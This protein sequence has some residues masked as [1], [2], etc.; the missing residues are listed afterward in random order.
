MKFVKNSSIVLGI[1]LMTTLNIS[2]C[3]ASD[4]HQSVGSIPLKGIDKVSYPEL[5][6]ISLQDAINI[7]SKIHP[8]KII[9]VALEKEAGFLVYEVELISSDNK[10]KEIILDAGNGEVLKVEVKNT[11]KR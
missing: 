6:K 3:F 11:K 2:V 4:D 8:G 9:E 7:V 1:V 5:A 10:K